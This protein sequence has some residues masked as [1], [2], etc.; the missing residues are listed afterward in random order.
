M[1]EY[2]KQLREM[3]A[4][5]M[6]KL[7]ESLKTPENQAVGQDFSKAVDNLQKED[8]YGSSS[9]KEAFGLFINTVRKD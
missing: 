7:N 1:L 6:H 3:P 8:Y 2:K 5:V 9:L 4:E